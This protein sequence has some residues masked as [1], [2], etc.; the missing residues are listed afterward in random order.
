MYVIY[1]LFLGSAPP[2]PHHP[3][4]PPQSTTSP[5]DR[6]LQLQQGTKKPMEKETNDKIR[7]FE[8][9]CQLF[10]GWNFSDICEQC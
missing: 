10:C 1:S 6:P 7:C 9:H 4:P 3:Q 5:Y 8:R 2:R